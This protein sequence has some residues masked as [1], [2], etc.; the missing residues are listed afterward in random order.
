MRTTRMALA[1]AAGLLLGMS[2]A[3]HAAPG[4]AVGF[5]DGWTKVK[6]FN[7]GVN[8]DNLFVVYP[9]S[10]TPSKYLLT[11]EPAWIIPLSVLCSNGRAF[12]VYVT[13]GVWTNISY[14]PPQ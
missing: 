8:Q 13:N 7:C 2:G 3:A 14:S 10:G 5:A 6:A 9:L 4:T 11:K 12:S 1:L